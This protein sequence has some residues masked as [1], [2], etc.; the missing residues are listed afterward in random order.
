MRRNNKNNNHILTPNERLFYQRKAI[1]GTQQ[2]IEEC[3]KIV[4]Q[5]QRNPNR[6]ELE[7]GYNYNYKIAG[8]NKEITEDARK[9]K[10][11]VKGAARLVRRNIRLSG[12]DER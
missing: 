8:R 4:N 5:N 12:M 10:R 11:H 7:E 3:W 1:E 9:F 6:E 2:I